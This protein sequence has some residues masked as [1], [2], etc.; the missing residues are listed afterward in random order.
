MGECGEM[1]I[2]FWR[3]K[4][5]KASEITEGKFPLERLGWTDEK[6]LK[7]AGAGVTPEEIDLF[8]AGGGLA[9]YGDGSDGNETTAGGGA[10]DVT[11]S[12][13]MFYNNL[14]VTAGD[15]ITAG[16]Y[17]IFV[18]G[19]LTNGGTIERNGNFPPAY[20]AA[21]GLTAGS[22]GGSAAGGAGDGGAGGGGGGAGVLFIAARI[23]VNN[24]IISANGGNGRDAFADAAANNDGNPGAA[25]TSSLGDNGG[26]GGD[27]GAF[28]GG[29]GGVAT[30]PTAV[31]S[32][33]R[34]P[35]L[36]IILKEIET[37][38]VKIAG[39][40]GGGSGSF[41][42]AANKG[43]G[44]GGGGGCL[45]LI[46]NSLTSGTETANG[47]TGGAGFGTGDAGANGSDGEIILL[48]NA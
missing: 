42:T 2:G 28:T 9:K 41:A 26:K 21:G 30:A 31:K 22:L 25:S 35:S 15:T 13:D 12:R 4:T 29:A 32:G 19:T 5:R 38:V 7:G 11:L 6:L 17:R 16:G 48:P 27:S 34:A 14:T 24:G 39:G 40:A 20:G 23:I 8:A 33:F 3:A 37:T 44:G 46:Y 1:R 45:V 43:G 36:A 47:G 10:G 18:K